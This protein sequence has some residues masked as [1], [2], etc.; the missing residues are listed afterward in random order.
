MDSAQIGIIPVE[1]ALF[2]TY[3]EVGR[4][5]YLQHYLHLWEDRDPT[6]YFVN[7]FHE[8]AVRKEW[9]DPHCLLF[10]IQ[11]EDMPA[12][13]LK[14]L[15]NINIPNAKGTDG[16]FLERIYLLNAYSGRGLGTYIMDF[17]ED[18]ALKNKKNYLWLESMQKGMA[19]KFYQKRGFV[20]IGEKLLSYPGL[21]ASERP[22]FI[23]SKK[24]S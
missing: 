5:S 2:K 24:L 19:L 8:D 12:G 1:P 22:M 7:S 11:V 16:L 10:L 6:P 23:M 18:L 4:R 14:I 9:E 3:I 20:V 21:V 15:L 13:I 17:I